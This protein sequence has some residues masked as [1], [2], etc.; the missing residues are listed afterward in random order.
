MW[1]LEEV[2][3]SGAP[4]SIT[5]CQWVLKQMTLSDV[6]KTRRVSLTSINPGR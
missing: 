2:V 1:V 6:P 3:R 5:T 4:E